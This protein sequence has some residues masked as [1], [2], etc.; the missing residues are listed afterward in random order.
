MGT[1]DALDEL[2]DFLHR[3]RGVDFS[4]YKRASLERRLLK[5][6]NAVGAVDYSGYL[7]YLQVHPEEFP[8]LFN[9]VLIN[10]TGFFR[11]PDTWSALRQEVLPPLLAARSGQS[12]RAWS[13]GCASGEEAYTITM[14]LAEIMGEEEVLRRVKVYATDMDEDALRQARQG[15]YSAKDVEALPAGFLDRYFVQASS[16]FELRKDLRR[17]VI[18]GRHDL[19]KDAP[20]SRIDLLACRN[21]LMYLNAET[22]ARILGRFRFAVNDDGILL[23][24]R[25]EMLLTQASIFAPVDLKRHIFAPIAKGDVPP[26]VARGRAPTDVDPTVVGSAY[27]AGASAQ[28]AIDASGALTLANRRAR[29]TFGLGPRDLGR[30][31]QDLEVSYRPVNLRSLI[32]QVYADGRPAVVRDVERASVEAEP[33]FFDVQITPLRDRRGLLGAQ[34]TFTDVTEAS[35]LRRELRHANQQ[36]EI[37][38]AELQ[39]TGEELETTN[40]EL[41]STIEELETM[42]EELQ[43]TNEEL[44]ATNEELQSSNEELFALNDSLRQRGKEVGDLN[45]FLGAILSSLRSAVV[46][47]DQDM[48][49]EIWNRRAEELW[50]LRQDEVRG[51]SLMALDIGLPTEQLHGTIKACLG[52]EE[53]KEVTLEAV[54]RRGRPIRCSVS[55]TRL[56]GESSTRGTVVVVRE[57]ETADARGGVGRE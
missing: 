18:F 15:V 34:I 19:V 21:T 30:P 53:R 41:Q 6:M 29:E 50:G 8:A 5:R 57:V 48:R 46:V 10:V 43:S 27:A 55:C 12:I 47:V 23:L 25:A 3:A 54:N 1:P 36:V 51:K 32:D 38:Y 42:N 28:L 9:T 37:A 56:A 45:L 16:K 2:L 17:C 20:I 39:S 13:A 14:V 44:E 40:E 33:S 4:G 11:D 26:P 31:I 52:G 49:I 22:Q 35:Q 24:G 7:D